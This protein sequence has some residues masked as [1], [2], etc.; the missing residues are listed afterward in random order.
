MRSRASEAAIAMSRPQSLNSTWIWPPSA[1]AREFIVLMPGIVAMASSTGR[2]RLRSTS[3][4][5]E[6]G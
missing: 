5:V 3:S 4:G 6:P 1:L 2:S